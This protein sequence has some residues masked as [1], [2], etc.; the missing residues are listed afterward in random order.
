VFHVVLHDFLTSKPIVAD[1]I[2]NTVKY[3]M[4]FLVATCRPYTPAL[5]VCVYMYIRVYV[6]MYV[7]QNTLILLCARSCF[8]NR[9]IKLIIWSETSVSIGTALQ[10]IYKV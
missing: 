7:N 1:Q 3:H 5:Y 8:L 2:L 4:F 6:D 10:W 9:K